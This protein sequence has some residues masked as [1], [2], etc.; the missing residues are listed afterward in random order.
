MR[1]PTRETPETLKRER[2]SCDAFLRELSHWHQ[3]RFTAEKLDKALRID[4]K[5]HSQAILHGLLE[6]RGRDPKYETFDT[7]IVDDIKLRAGFFF[8]S[9]WQ[10]P[11]YFVYRFG[12]RCY[13][14]RLKKE[15]ILFS[16]MGGRTDRPDSPN[17]WDYV[18]HLSPK[19]FTYFATLPEP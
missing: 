5:L 15:D 1:E 2:E 11:F 9:I 19:S 17:D 13:W 10:V 4:F 14:A 8:S 18:A 6:C 7:W 16:E 3:N 12:Q